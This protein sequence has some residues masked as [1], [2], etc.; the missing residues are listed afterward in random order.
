MPCGST[1]PKG[2]GDAAA[3]APRIKTGFDALLN[4]ALKGKNA[5]TAPIVRN[6]GTISDSDK[7][8]QRG[9]VGWKAY[10]GCVILNQ[11]FISRLECGA[12]EL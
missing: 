8:G 7:L 9:H 5:I 11:L 2:G 6:P 12:T 3:W 4:S 10:F 1:L